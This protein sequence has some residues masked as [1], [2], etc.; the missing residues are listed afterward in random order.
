MESTDLKAGINILPDHASALRNYWSRSADALLDALGSN[1]LGLDT[2]VIPQRL[3]A[4]GRN[5]L[6]LDR[7]HRL[8]I[9]IAKAI[10]Q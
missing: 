9:W 5:T 1:H 6:G 7:S 4:F 10:K 8:T 3:Q 2:A